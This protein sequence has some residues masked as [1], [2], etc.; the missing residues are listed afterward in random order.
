VIVRT[1]SER[2]FRRVALLALAGFAM[3]TCRDAPPPP[4]PPPS[5]IVGAENVAVVERGPIAT[6][7]IVTGALEP[8]ERAAM[9]AE[10]SGSVEQVNVELGDHVG[11]GAVLARID[12]KALG[13]ALRS[14]RSAVRARLYAKQ[15]A[16]RQLARTRRLVEAGA[17]P[18]HELE[19]SKNMLASE[20][21]ELSRARAALAGA[22][23]ELEG[24]VVRAPFSG[25]ISEKAVHEGDVVRVGAPLFTLIDPSSM[26]LR[27]SV[28]SESLEQ[29]AV[30]APV[31]FRVRGL[32]EHEF[33]GKIERVGPAADPVT[34]QI[35]LLISL[36]NP[37][38]RLVAG[39]FAEGRIAAQ[40]QTGLLVPASAVA[41]SGDATSVRRVDA[42]QIEEVPVQ[43]GMED[44]VSDIVLVSGRLREGDRVLTGPARELE[45]GT[46]VRIAEPPP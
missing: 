3:A 27:A 12:A 41:L 22:R 35:P 9:I 16:Q 14:A 29:L 10:A 5:V 38:G 34:R 8:R 25:V 40:E 20:K 7:P 26:R 37:T 46:S 28:P 18:E 30:G 23:E 17:L 19:L 4:R 21:A 6:G 42:D 39:L 36:P 45:G 24:A 32:G 13:L 2:R 33:L 31:S 1:A 11:R 44:P 15:V 43:V